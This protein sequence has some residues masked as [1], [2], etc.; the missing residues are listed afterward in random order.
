MFTFWS[1]EESIELKGIY[2]FQFSAEKVPAGYELC[3]T[4][5]VY[6]GTSK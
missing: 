2:H 1:G 5:D 3:E 4:G 6:I